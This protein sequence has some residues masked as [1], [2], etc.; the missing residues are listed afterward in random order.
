MRVG[1][2]VTG[3]VVN[4]SGTKAGRGF[5]LHHRRQH[6]ADRADIVLLKRD[7]PARRRSRG[8]GWGRGR[9]SQQRP[10]IRRWCT[11]RRRPAPAPAPPQR[12]PPPERPGRGAGPAAAP[13]PRPD[14]RRMPDHLPR[15]FCRVIV[16]H[17]GRTRH[18]RTNEQALASPVEIVALACAARN[19]LAL[20]QSFER[21]GELT[22]RITDA[23]ER[24]DHLRRHRP[25]RRGAFPGRCRL[26]WP[27]PSGRRG[28]RR[29][30][31][32]RRTK[33]ARR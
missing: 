14:R 13:A 5:D 25:S 26:W 9:R 32:I 8:C 30:R 19:N 21:I 31:F 11:R 20:P 6:P 15:R 2:D 1:H 23:H 7:A 27:G 22:A 3:G 24:P 12:H 28:Q 4:H 29:R 16:V 17:R 33:A 18:H 10:S